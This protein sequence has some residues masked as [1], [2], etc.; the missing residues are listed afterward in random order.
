LIADEEEDFFND[1]RELM[2]YLAKGE[3]VYLDK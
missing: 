3:K 2:E 1:N